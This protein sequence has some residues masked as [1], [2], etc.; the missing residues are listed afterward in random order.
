MFRSRNPQKVLSKAREKEYVFT[1]GLERFTKTPD[2]IHFYTGFPDYE[3]LVA[4]WNYIEPSAC[5]LTCYSSVRDATQVNTDDVFPFL[6]TLGKK[7]PGRNG[8]TQR[9]LQAIDEFWLFL[10][11]LKLGLFERDLALRFNI[12]I[13][14]VSDIM[15]TFSNYLFV[16]LESL[17]VWASKDI[18][19]QHL[20]KACQGRFENVRCIIDCTEI[21]CE[22]PED[23]QN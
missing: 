12:S 4:F 5:H 8:G 18:I 15:I 1:F 11:R 23:L 21:K 10:T 9:S 14:T 7:F 20:P 19:K 22:N 2:D 16:M 6:N 3:T 17:L 13:P